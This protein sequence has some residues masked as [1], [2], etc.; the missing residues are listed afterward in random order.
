MSF[1]RCRLNIVSS[2]RT[3]LIKVFMII[4]IDF[5]DGNA[6]SYQ[7]SGKSAEMIK[8]GASFEMLSWHPDH[9]ETCVIKTADCNDSKN[10]RSD[11]WV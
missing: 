10:I 5:E 7:V 1:G 4:T 11:C 9:A 3:A 8:N 2:P 6:R